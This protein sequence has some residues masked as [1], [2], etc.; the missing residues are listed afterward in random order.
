YLFDF[1]PCCCIHDSRHMLTLFYV[2]ED[3]LLPLICLIDSQMQVVP[4]Y[5]LQHYMLIT[6]IQQFLYIFLN[7]FC[8]RGC[9]S[10]ESRFR[11]QGL[12]DR[13]DFLVA[14][15]EIMA[16]FGNTM[17]LIK[18]DQRYIQFTDKPAEFFIVKSFGRDI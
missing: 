4:L 7:F 8:R 5:A 3:E 12:D 15:S 9:Q 1:C 11:Y 14:R 10:H 17:R 13:Y 16:P 2:R 18:C 6:D